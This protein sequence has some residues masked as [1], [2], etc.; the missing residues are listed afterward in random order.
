MAEDEVT[1]V[2]R[3]E[4]QIERLDCEAEGERL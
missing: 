1:G 3:G 4:S 2:E